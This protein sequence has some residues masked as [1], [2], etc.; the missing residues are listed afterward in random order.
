MGQPP[1]VG[2]GGAKHSLFS[3]L[4]RKFR[5]SISKIL[6][7]SYFPYFSKESASTGTY[8]YQCE[9]A[10][11]SDAA[12]QQ[13]VKVDNVQLGQ[14]EAVMKRSIFQGSALERMLDFAILQ[15]SYD[16]PVNRNSEIALEKKQY[17]ECRAGYKNQQV[18]GFITNGEL[19]N[20]LVP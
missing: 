2:G 5:N 16:V 3:S 15:E 12:G 11:S 20:V 13:G 4:T 7:F 8:C 17:L 9:D 19:E 1:N 10:K 6:R 14:S 18:A